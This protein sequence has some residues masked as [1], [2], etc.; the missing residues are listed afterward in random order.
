[1]QI[2]YI[3]GK[4]IVFHSTGIVSECT[5]SDK[6]T[7]VKLNNQK[8]TKLEIL[9]LKLQTDKVINL[10]QLAKPLE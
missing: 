8:I 9:V 6:Q 5:V 7:Q 2:E 1:M 4:Q 10:I 3:N